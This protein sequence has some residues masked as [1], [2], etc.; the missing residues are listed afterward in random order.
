MVFGTDRQNSNVV[1]MTTSL[2]WGGT[3]GHVTDLAIGFVKRGIFP[4]VL[5][6]KP[7]LDRADILDR[8]GVKVEVVMNG[9]SMTKAEY[10]KTLSSILTRI[11][12]SLIHLNN[13]ER[14]PCILSVIGGLKIPVIETLHTTIKSK[15]RLRAKIRY[16]FAIKAIREAYESTLPAVINISE[17]S[18][19]NFCKVYPFIKNTTRVYCGAYFPKESND[20]KAGGTAVKVIWVGSFIKRKRPV[21]ALNIWKRIL[22][23]FPKTQLVM[24]GDGP[25]MGKVKAIV[26]NMPPGSVKLCGNIPD[27]YPVLKEG[28][29]MLHTSIAEGIPKNIRYALNFGIPVVTTNV[30]AISEAVID[31]MN[32]FLVDVSDIQLMEDRLRRLICNSTLREAMGMQGRQLGDR[33]FRLDVMINNVLGAYKDFYGQDLAPRETNLSNDFLFPL[34]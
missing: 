25:E 6:D 18:L 10:I 29:I 2:G 30:G 11:N 31:G 17:R 28:H 9:K 8:L 23:D 5:A 15:V 12:P 16:F 3:E 14:R 7:P 4:V 13:W 34:T 33:L 27:L 32:G 22:I 24:V 1:L 26:K 19:Q 21:V 20:V